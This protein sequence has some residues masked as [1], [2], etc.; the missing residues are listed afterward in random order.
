VRQINYWEPA[1]RNAVQADC[2][3]HLS[4]SNATF[5]PY[6]P[7]ILLHFTLYLMLYPVLSV[8]PN[9]YL[10]WNTHETYCLPCTDLLFTEWWKS[11]P[12]VAL[13]LSFKRTANFHFQLNVS[14]SIQPWHTT[15]NLTNIHTINVLQQANGDSNRK[16]SEDEY[17]LHRD[18]TYTSNIKEHNIHHHQMVLHLGHKHQDKTLLSWWY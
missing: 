16:L 9:F 7:D 1:Y 18:F 8:F 12:W 11:K 14:H 13:E 2:E 6:F 3:I 10:H 15:L 5:A 17:E 4:W